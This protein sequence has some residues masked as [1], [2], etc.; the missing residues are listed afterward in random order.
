M[1]SG[2]FA[3]ASEEWS[4]RGG[5]ASKLKHFLA[6][7][8]SGVRKILPFVTFS[9]APGDKLDLPFFFLDG[10]GCNSALTFNRDGNPWITG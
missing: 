6:I 10:G 7:L 1:A 4:L 3:I 5:E 9:P 8:P 2:D